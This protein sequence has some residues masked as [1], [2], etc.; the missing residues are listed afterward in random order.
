MKAIKPQTSKGPADWFT[1]DVYPTIVLSGEA[2]SRVRTASERPE[3]M[4][5]LSRTWRYRGDRLGSGAV[6]ASRCAETLPQAIEEGLANE[7]RV[8]RASTTL[9]C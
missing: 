6:R 7:L 1:G 5:T 9:G 4:A 8:L 2:P 3:G